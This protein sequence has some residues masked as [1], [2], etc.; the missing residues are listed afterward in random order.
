MTISIITPY[1]DAARW[2]P[3]CVSSLIAQPGDF[4]FILV[5]DNSTDNGPE[6]VKGYA[7]VDKRIKAVENV[8]T[9]GVSGARNTGLDNATG[10]Y[11]TFLDADDLLDA[12]AY[13]VYNEAI[14]T[15][16]RIIQMN[17]WRYYESIGKLTKKYQN[18]PGDFYNIE[19]L[20]RC[21]CM[22]WNKLFAR[23]AIA[24]IWFYEG[25]Q[26]GEDELFVLEAMTYDDRITHVE[27]SAVIHCYTN[28]QSLT[29]AKD[30]KRL[31]DQSVNLMGLLIKYPDAPRR[32]RQR[33]CRIIANH[34]ES[35][36]YRDIFGA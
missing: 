5:N 29:K 31:L 14:K 3:V 17:H 30:K 28:R 16:A 25:Q 15:G 18:V 7:L 10:E 8:R 33:L 23:E 27:G 24:N 1:R 13:K 12:D 11:I 26:Y 4:K 21:Y 2:L 35:K 22:V 36:V 32:Y 6:L 20:P 19:R 34:W 9:P